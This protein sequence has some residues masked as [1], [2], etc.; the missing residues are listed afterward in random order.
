[1]SVKPTTALSDSERNARN[2]AV[3]S[4]AGTWASQ[5]IDLGGRNTL[6]YYRDLKVGTLDLTDASAASLSQLLDGRTV[7]LSKLFPLERQ[8][9]VARRSRTVTA[10]SKENFEERGL[11]T[12]YIACGMATWTA[13]S[14]S[15]ATPAAPVLLAQIAIRSLGASEADYELTITDDWEPNPTLLHL[16]ASTHQ[17]EIAADDLLEAVERTGNLDAANDALKQLAAA[18]P[19]FSVSSRTV[20]GNF[21]YVKQPMVLDLESAIDVMADNDLIAALAGD[22]AAVAALRSASIGV[23]TDQPDRS[24]PADEFIPID[25]DASQHYVINAAVNGVH[26]VVQGPPG[27]GK[28]Q[29]IANLI[30]T[31]SAR[32]RSVLFV[33]EKRAAIEAVVSRLDRVGLKD[34]VL[35]LHGGSSRK[36]MAQEL[37]RVYDGNSTVPA[38]SRDSDDAR[39]ESRRTRLNSHAAALHERRDPWGLSAYELQSLLIGVPEAL[40]VPQRLAGRDLAALSGPTF[41]IV[42][43]AISDW[44]TG[45]GPSVDRQLTPWSRASARVTTSTEAEAAL[46]CARLLSSDTLPSAVNHLD[47]AIGTC[48]LL[49][50]ASIAIWSDTLA[51]LHGVAEVQASAQP[52]IW[53]LDLAALLT[54]LQPATGSGVSRAT[55]TAFN[56]SYRKAKK[57]IGEVLR[58][59]LKGHDLHRIVALAVSTKAD[60]LQ[61]C[62]DGGLPRLPANLDGTSGSYS[63]LT[64]ELAALGA[65]VGTSGLM[66]TDTPETQRSIEALLSDQATLFK[67]PRLHDLTVAIDS[68]G[69]AGVRS[70]VV[71]RGLDAAAARKMSEYTWA[72]SILDH[73]CLHDPEVG[74]FDGATHSKHVQEFVDADRSQIAAGA[75]KVRRAVAENLINVRNANPQGD[76]LVASEVKK[77]SRHR[78]LRELTQMAPDVLLALK[79]CWAMSPLAV[80]QLLDARQLFDVVVFDEASQVP[81]ADA[82]PALMRAKQAIVA[83]DAKQ[84]PPTA[85]FASATLDDEADAESQLGD[86]T[87]GS[88]SVLDAM[89]NVVTAGS[90]TLRWHYRS[91]DERLIAFSNAQPSL[92]DWQMVTFPGTAG[93][94]AIRHIH[95]PWKASAGSSDESSSAEVQRVVELITDHAHV[96]PELTLGV[97]AM[98]IKHAERITAALKQ[99]R[100][101][102]PV[103]DEFCDRD[104]AEPSFVKNL[105]RVQGDE[106]DAIILSVGF[107]KGP[108]GRMLYRFGPINNPGGERRLNVAVTRARSQ[109]TVVSSFLPTD[110]DPTKLRSEGAKML[111]RY[112]TYA[113][114]GGADLGPVHLTHPSLNHFEVDVRDRL[115]AAGVKL[116]P[117]LGVSGYFID[118]AACHPERPGEFVLAIEADGA[119]YHASATA[120][121]RDRLRQD[122]LERLGWRFHRIWSTDWFRNREAEIAKAVVAWEAAIAQSDQNMVSAG[123]SAFVE[124]PEPGPSLVSARVAEPEREAPRRLSVRPVIYVGMQIDTYRPEQLVDIVTWVASDGYLRTDS[125]LLDAVV[126]AMGYKKRGS[127]IVERLQRAIGAYRLREKANRSAK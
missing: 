55:A 72:A 126:T 45:G 19:G 14:T 2:A 53:S 104:P 22:G 34:L 25:A 83:G 93:H 124:P 29:T 52:A 18:V 111:G 10:K 81:P 73:V 42:A 31:L 115:T 70:L 92:Y 61:R 97:I 59:P 122:H 20:V 86:L 71:E 46:L 35:D 95:V 120:R 24:P 105:E 84:L 23:G 96:T 87:T 51:L 44:V 4:A 100:N 21:S 108:D 99:A 78:T 36:R 66:D 5:L 9:E 90:M 50:P 27:T 89:A 48:G 110:L 32:G 15:T 39:L 3:R 82:I 63:R 98:G 74:A 107:G 49:R 28:S 26:L 103:L 77:K 127:K 41:E 1:M 102:D 121:E 40:R 101:G 8:A 75:S 117:Q 56:S 76:A 109:M 58:S 125:E 91:R 12:L 85:F 54:D 112:L 123:D 119:S 116:V 43:D 47:E 69:L 6:L 65:Y 7:R 106:R 80:S 64:A 88:E 17:V 30:A 16:L 79:P 118:F 13:D 57:L 113:A 68:A 62:V 33:A 11:S 114:S 37:R 94:D 60:W 38:V 67:L